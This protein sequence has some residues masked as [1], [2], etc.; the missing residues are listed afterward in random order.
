MRRIRFWLVLLFLLTLTPAQA[1]DN[2]LRVLWMHAPADEDLYEDVLD[3]FVE[4]YEAL[5]PETEVEIILV[6]WAIGQDAIK[7]SLNTGD[8]PDIAVIGAR[9]VPEFVSLGII[10]PLDRYITP[11]FRAEFIPAII[12][13][14]AVY[15]GRLFGLPIATSTR[16]LFYNQDLF[17][18]AG[19]DVDK[20][21]QTWDDLTEA[22]RRITD[23]ANRTGEPV[24]G[25]GLQGGGGVE[26]NTY[27][28]YFVWGNGGDIYD[29]TRTQ[30]ALD[31]PEAVDAL[32]YVRGLID[33]GFTQPAPTDIAYERRRGVEDL[34]QA[35]RLGMVISGP[36]FVNRLRAEAPELNFGVAPLPYKTTPVTYGVMDAITIL[37]TSTNKTRA[38]DFLRFLYAPERR[39]LYTGQLGVLPEL[40]TVADDPVFAQDPEYAVF[41]SLLDQAR[42]EPPHI[43]S[44]AIAQIVIDALRG[45]YQGEADPQDALDA[46]SAEID[47]LLG[48]AVA[49]W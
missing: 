43:Q 19:L 11:D 26:T 41:L 17:A 25:F 16:A 35:G 45:V 9:W 2:T 48:G 4:E 12:D 7:R 34:F 29:P 27:F 5:N 31:A 30:S 21:P 18:Q 10:E 15:Q 49:G 13:E 1:Q 14:G 36:W 47:T 3:V 44:E 37:R 24:Y 8:P 39:L 22:A 32:R 40:Q 23:Y 46:A 6:D 42:F 33:A 20:P 28:Y 38:W